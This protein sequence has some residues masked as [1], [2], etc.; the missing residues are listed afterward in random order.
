ME[1]KTPPVTTD[2]LIQVPLAGPHFAYVEWAGHQTR[3][4][5]EEQAWAAKQARPFVEAKIAEAKR[6][7][8]C[9]FCQSASDPEAHKLEQACLKLKGRTLGKF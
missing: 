6:K 4:T 2:Q 9:P 3:L 5:K 1:A 7:H 8:A